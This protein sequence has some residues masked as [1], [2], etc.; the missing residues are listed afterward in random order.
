MTVNIRGKEYPRNMKKHWDTRGRSGCV[1]VLGYRMFSVGG[2]KDAIHRYEH[3]MVMEKKL[4]RKLERS[5]HVHHIN[6]NKLDNRIE[7]L[8]LLSNSEHLRE[9]AIKSGLGKL[10]RPKSYGNQHGGTLSKNMVKRIINLRDNGLTFMGISK[11]LGISHSVA[12]KY[13]KLCQS[14]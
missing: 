3:R 4:G 12:H 14:I 6:G 8:E 9:H 2:R 10:I 7:N 5:E 11:K 1:T 13:V